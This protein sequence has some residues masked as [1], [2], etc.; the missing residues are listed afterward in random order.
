MDHTNCSVNRYYLF[1]TIGGSCT[2]SF[3]QKNTDLVVSNASHK[4]VKLSKAKEWGIPVHEVQWLYDFFTLKEPTKVEYQY[5]KVL[6]ED[7]EPRD[8]SLKLQDTI[9]K[10]NRKLKVVFTDCEDTSTTSGTP[11]LVEY[12]EVSVIPRSKLLDE[13]RIFMISGVPVNERDE[14]MEAIKRLGGIVSRDDKWTNTC[15]TLII[16]RPLKTEKF[17]CA[18]AK[19][20]P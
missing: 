3:S 7:E 19:C 2:S 20:I 4:S 1:L 11:K 18:S 14:I 15:S 16:V 12:G 6:E 9:G 5:E 10:E 8:S 13:M 17:L